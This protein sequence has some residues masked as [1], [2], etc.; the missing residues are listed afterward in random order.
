MSSDQDVPEAPV[1]AISD[2]HLQES[3]PE[4]T[5]AFVDFIA[6]VP[7]ACREFFILGDLFELWIGDDADSPLGDEVASALRGLAGRGVQVYLMHGNRDFLIGEAFA[8]R[9]GALLINEPWRLQVEG[10]DWLLLHGDVLC[11]DDK[12]Y[13]EFREMV[14]NPDWQREF[15]ARPVAERQAWAD[16]AREASQAATAGKPAEIMDV[17]QHA[18]RKLIRDS[19]CPRILHGHTHRPAVHE[20]PDCLSDADAA[21][22]ATPARRVVLGDWD[23][24]GWY[25]A[26]AGDAFTLRSFDLKLQSFDL[27]LQSFDL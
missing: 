26:I 4:L 12:A 24:K 25:V 3:R 16:R 17:N 20:L 18:V 10:A 8:E 22:A 1:I 19:G 13:L 21:D 15:L 5:R 11:T 7:A 2:L 23:T 14:R 6:R 27:T 9:C